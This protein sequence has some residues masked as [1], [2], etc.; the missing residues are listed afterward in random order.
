MDNCYWEIDKQE[1]LSARTSAK[2]RIVEG[3][4]IKAKLWVSIAKGNDRARD[5]LGKSAVFTMLSFEQV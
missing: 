2:D 5:R 4:A 3:L 1:A